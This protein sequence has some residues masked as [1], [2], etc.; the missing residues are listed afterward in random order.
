LAGGTDRVQQL[1]R[2]KL[3]LVEE[4]ERY[5]DA[6][7]AALQQLGWCIDYF[8]R[9]KNGRIARA[10]STNQAEIRRQYLNPAGRATRSGKR[11]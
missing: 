11:A 10:L 5:R 1:E 4:V 7:E 3:H 8:T 9:N 2:E 6:A